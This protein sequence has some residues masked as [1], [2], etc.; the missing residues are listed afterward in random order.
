MSFSAS[1]LELREPHDRRARN[2]AVLDAVVKA[3]ADRS[4]VAITDLACGT[5]STLRALSP[6]LKA[7]QNWRLADNDLSLLARTPES[8]PPGLMVSTTPVDLERDLEAA[9]DGPADLVTT[10]ALLDLVSDAWLNR[11]AVEVAAR[12]LP[13]YA[14]LSYDGRVD[15]TPSDP[16]DGAIVAAVNQH[17][18]TDKGFGPALGPD[19][20][21]LAPQRFERVGY[22]VVQ[23]AS[24]WVFGPNDRE[25]QLETLTGWATAAREMGTVPLPEVVSWLTRRRDLVAAGRSTIRVGHIDLFAR[26]TGSR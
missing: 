6:R 26:P 23:G 11:L 3:F 14:A 12:R 7:R 1:W 9:L 4:S 17:Q 13:V 19:A 24:D 2:A 16:G 20:A 25:I 5:G 8:R 10:S 18:R 15:M 21:K 22:A